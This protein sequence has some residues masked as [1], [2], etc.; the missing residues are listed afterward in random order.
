MHHIPNNLWHDRWPIADIVAY[1]CITTAIMPAAVS[2]KSIKSFRSNKTAWIRKLLAI[3]LA[4]HHGGS[5]QRGRGCAVAR[6]GGGLYPRNVC[7]VRSR[8]ARRD[9]IAARDNCRRGA[10]AAPR[11]IPP[12]H[13]LETPT[14]PSACA[15]RSCFGKILVGLALRN[16]E[17]NIFAST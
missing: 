8:S 15:D 17:S 10:A 12:R 16:L 11:I 13:P 9:G 7:M 6:R 5:S 4:C 2:T 1:V 14:D 3:S